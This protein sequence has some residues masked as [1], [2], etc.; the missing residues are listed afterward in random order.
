MR[1]FNAGYF[2]LEG[3]R[4]IRSHGLMSFAAVS[5]IM[6]CLIIM[7]SFSLVAVNASNMLGDLED[8]NVFLAYVQEDYTADQV[9]ALQKQV[10]AVPN[11]DKV[12]Y[13]TKAQAKSDYLKGREDS[14]LY[15]DLPETVFRDR[16]SIHVTDITQFQTTVD[17]V[18]ALPG[19]ANIRAETA[20][21]EGFVMVSNVARAIATI[22]IVILALISLFIISNTIKLATFT[23]RNEIAIMKMC[24][25]TNSFVRWPFI[26]EGLTLGLLGAIVAYFAEWGI[27]TLVGNAIVQNNAATFIVL[28]P[29]KYLAWRVAGIFLGAGAAIGAIGSGMA[30]RKFLQV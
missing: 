4:S 28:V 15:A 14:S 3:F 30:I 23:R 9:A 11:V 25:A 19:I 18:K 24:G 17:A 2:I 6:A 27:Y 12:E 20:I 5:M 21:A 10:E 7:G 29:F 26:F 8:E 22:L 1:R 13:I 16:F